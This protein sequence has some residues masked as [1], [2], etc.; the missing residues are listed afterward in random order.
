MEHRSVNGCVCVGE[1][2]VSFHSSLAVYAEMMGSGGASWEFC[3]S[4]FYP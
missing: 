2:F 3:N 1:C 4:F